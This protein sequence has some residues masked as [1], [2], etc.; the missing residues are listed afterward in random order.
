LGASL[1]LA[2]NVALGVAI[3]VSFLA[4]GLFDRNQKPAL[5]WFAACIA[6]VSSGLIEYSMPPLEYTAIA[7]FAIYAL[8]AVCL[9]CISIG[10]WLRYL[11]R[12]PVLPMTIV[13]MAAIVSYALISELPRSS[14]LRAFVYQGS[15]SAIALVGVFAVWRGMDRSALDRTLMAVMLLFALN[16][17]MKPPIM[18]LLGGNGGVAQDYLATDYAMVSQTMMAIV[19]ILLAFALGLRTMA[20]ILGTIQKRSDI[21]RL[22]GALTRDA[23]HRE[24]SRSLW[25]ADRERT[26]KALILCDLDH[27]KLVNDT[28]GHQVGDLVIAQFGALLESFRR[29]GD[30]VGR[31]G[32]EEFCILLSRCDEG[33]ARLF[34]EQLRSTFESL[35]ATG[36][37]SAR[38][39]TASFGVTEMRPAEAFEAAFSRVDKALYEAKS[40]G[41]N[42]V[43]FARPDIEDQDAAVG[44]AVEPDALQ[45]R[46]SFR[47]VGRTQG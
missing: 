29:P 15:Y 3:M 32:G 36:G 19:T 11:R 17:L 13:F 5:W 28:F 21:D 38:R 9:S 2:I 12:V 7:R 44:G 41:R 34:A 33:T 25:Q 40:A 22:S 20:D 8:F 10:L 23:F 39:C 18:V 46:R 35:D 16:F 43:R 45:K 37:R 27:F 24:V 31:I 14:L 30:V 47:V 1:L 6:G 4:F 42:C 26:P